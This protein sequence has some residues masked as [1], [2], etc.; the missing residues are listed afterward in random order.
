MPK[1]LTDAERESRKIYNVASRAVRKAFCYWPGR[2]QCLEEAKRPHT[3]TNKRQ[4]WEYLCNVCGGWFKKDDVQV[5]H[6][7]PVG[8]FSHPNHHKPFITKM[9]FGKLQVLCKACHVLKCNEEKK[10]GAYNND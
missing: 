6:I 1:K 10:T 4:K 5:D 9:F 3:G 7:E 2:K 8:A